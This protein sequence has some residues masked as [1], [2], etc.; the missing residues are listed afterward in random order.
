MTGAEEL[1]GESPLG[2][3]VA[4][5]IARAPEYEVVFDLMLGF[6]LTFFEATALERRDIDRERRWCR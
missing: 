6:G 2:R 3:I 1:A 5:T 4:E